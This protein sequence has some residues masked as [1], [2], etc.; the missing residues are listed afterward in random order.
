MGVGI[1]AFY[2]KGFEIKEQFPVFMVKNGWHS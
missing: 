1:S 2:R